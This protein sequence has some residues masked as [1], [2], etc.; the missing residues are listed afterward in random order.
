MEPAALPGE[1]TLPPNLPSRV[2]R[3]P[4]I[5][6]GGIWMPIRINTWT[7]MTKDALAGP[8]LAYYFKQDKTM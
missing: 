1:G 7:G 5:K 3:C 6:A 8:C 4:C 2:G